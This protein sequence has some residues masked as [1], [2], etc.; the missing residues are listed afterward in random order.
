MGIVINGSVTINGRVM[1]LGNETNSCQIDE[2]KTIEG[3]VKEFVINSSCIDV[4]FLP[5]DNENIVIKLKGK[6]SKNSSIPKLDVKK[7][8][9]KLEINL[10][11][12][13]MM[14]GSITL[15]IMI[16]NKEYKSIFVK[17]QSA[18]VYFGN[19]VKCETITF[20]TMSGNIDVD[21][22]CEF[23]DLNT[24]S[25][26]I[27]ADIKASKNTSIKMKSM[28]GN[29]DLKLVNVSSAT[30]N[31]STCVGRVSNMFCESANGYIVTA[32]LIT[33]SGNIK[34]S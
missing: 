1:N 10:V 5:S 13:G 8:G 32:N 23:V 14:I 21:A 7:E 9:G 15:D 17:S 16:P 2:T 28:S 27:N 4:R 12:S 18:N 30:I 19:K 6:C 20:S 33:T 3:A 26:D 25:G 29:I 31:H 34:I 22:E 24:L 11:S